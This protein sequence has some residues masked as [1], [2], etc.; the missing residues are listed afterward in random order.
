IPPG[1]GPKFF[2]SFF[3]IFLSFFLVLIPGFFFP[4]QQAVAQRAEKEGLS[5]FDRLAQEATLLNQRGQP[6]KVITLL[7][8]Y[9]GDAKNDS[10]LFFNELGIA[11]RQRGR[12]S[13]AIQAYRSALSRD[14][15]NP[16]I[17][18]NLGD[19]FY[20]NQEYSQAVELYQKTLQANPRFQQAHSSLGLAYY[21]LQR[22]QESLEEFEIVLQLNPQDEQAKKFREAILK[23]IKGQK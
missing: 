9:Q 13:E 5:R 18:K 21:Q 11:Y 22:Y 20:L 3:P 15:E 16:V 6:E 14:P 8:P 19:A 23:K 17:M 12:I 10:A 4:A 7:E 2:P 1:E